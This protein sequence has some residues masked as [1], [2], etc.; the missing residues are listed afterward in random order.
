M[1]SRVARFCLLAGYLALRAS[2]ACN[3]YGVDFSNGGSYNIDTSSDSLFTFTSVFQ[4]CIQESV[5]P[6]LVDPSGHQYTCTA[7]NT[8]P[9]GQEATSS[10]AIAYSSMPSGQW[11]IVISGSNVAVQRVI[12]LTGVAP[13]TVIVT[14]T[15]TVTLGI[16]ST[17]KPTSA[18]LLNHWNTNT[19]SNLGDSNNHHS[20]QRSNNNSDSYADKGNR[21]QS[22]D[23][24]PHDY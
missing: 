9:D 18:R 11:K 22:I 7:I 19:N 15:P 12:N 5:R 13:S 21:R 24:S 17:P 20:M 3:V 4:G 14:A 8:T 23:Y 2:A 16:T 10:C 1:A 6:T